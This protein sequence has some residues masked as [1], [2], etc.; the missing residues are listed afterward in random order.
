MSHRNLCIFQDEADK[1]KFLEA[2]HDDK[3]LD[4]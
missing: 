2:L 1:E 3:A 4:D